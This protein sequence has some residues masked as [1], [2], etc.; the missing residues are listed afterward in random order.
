MV[1]VVWATYPKM[2][3]SVSIFDSPNGCD[4]SSTLTINAGGTVWA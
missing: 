2:R 3:T 4:L 1:V